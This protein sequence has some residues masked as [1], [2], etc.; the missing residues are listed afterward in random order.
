MIIRIRDNGNNGATSEF[1][2]NTKLRGDFPNKVLHNTIILYCDV[3][4]NKSNSLMFFGKLSADWNA[5]NTL[6]WEMEFSGDPSL[7]S[8]APKLTSASRD[9]RTDPSKKQ[10][11]LSPHS[12]LVNGLFSILK[13]LESSSVE[14]CVLWESNWTC[15]SH[16]PTSCLLVT[17]RFS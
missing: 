16:C 15:L 17:L 13:R 2:D 9:L 3:T 11:V 14:L 5:K 12:Q 10:V 6:L 8:P 7:Q 4:D 1:A